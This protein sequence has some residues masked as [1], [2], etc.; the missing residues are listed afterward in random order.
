M[1][2]AA[3]ASTCLALALLSGCAS[4]P[5]PQAPKPP[6]INGGGFLEIATG[7]AIPIADSS[8]DKFADPTGKLSLRLG[9]T[10]R[11]TKIFHFA[12]MVL[13]DWIPTNTDDATYSNGAL[14]LDAGFH[15]VRGLVGGSFN[16]HLWIVDFGLRLGLG[17]DYLRGSIVYPIVGRTAYSSVSFA[18]EPQLVTNFKVHRNVYIGVNVAVPIAQH[19]FGSGIG[20]VDFTSADF[21][22]LGVLG[23]RFGAAD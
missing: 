18:F 8:Y 12:P 15:R 21:D 16:I 9:W 22:V 2:R 13:V 4:A 3:L 1:R 7:A 23:F 14:R 10:I 19:T 20:K 11:L 5:P 17:A 6:S